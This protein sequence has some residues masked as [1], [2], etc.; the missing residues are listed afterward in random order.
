MG[1]LVAVIVSAAVGAFLTVG[2]IQ[3]AKQLW[4]SAPSWVWKVALPV[5]GVLAFIMLMLLPPGA[6]LWVFGVGLVIAASQLFYEV[7]VKL[8]N[9]LKDRIAGLVK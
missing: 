1:N 5:L 9:K 8:I 3:Y 2:L 4:A 6:T 7:V